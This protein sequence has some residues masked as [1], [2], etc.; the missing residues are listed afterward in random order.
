MGWLQ[1][2]IIKDG[3]NVRF[4]SR[5]GAEYT[6]RL[7]GMVE[8]FAKLPA[9]AAILDGE[10]CH[11]DPRGRAHFYRLMHQMR[12]SHPDES[13]LMFMAFDLLHQDGV[14]LRALPLS[15]RKR[16]LHR[17]CRKSP[18]PFMR[19]VQTFPN[20]TLLF[21]H[22]NKFSFEGVVSKRLASRYSSGPSRNWLK[23]KCPG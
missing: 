23:T 1:L 17:L 2:P 3:S 14:D 8:A 19:E 20:G 15:D 11:I 13:Q 16:D 9:R 22:C 6:D 10:L 18:V 21:E 7:P 4:Y 5:H 12:T